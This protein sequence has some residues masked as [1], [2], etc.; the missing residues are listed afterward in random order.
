MNN[1]RSN[2]TT[3]KHNIVD[4]LKNILFFSFLTMY[5]NIAIYIY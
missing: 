4:N 2:A 5:E 3:N 1:F